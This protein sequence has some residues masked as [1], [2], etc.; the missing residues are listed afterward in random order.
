MSVIYVT[1]RVRN[2]MVQLSFMDVIFNRKV[3]PKGTPMRTRTDLY[4]MDEKSD[5]HPSLSDD[6]IRGAEYCYQSWI[7]KLEEFNSKYESFINTEDKSAFFHTFWI[8]KGTKVPESQRKVKHYDPHDSR[9]RR[10]DAPNDD[11]KDAL[12]D[13][14]DIFENDF[15]V[16]YHT[17]AYAYV[18][19]RSVKDAVKR[20]QQND[21]R[22]FLKL[23]FSNFF[24]SVTPEF[25]ENMFSILYP[26]G[27]IFKY[28][29]DF[30]IE[31]KKALS[32]CFLNGGLPQGTPMSPLLTN[33]IMIPIDSEIARG[34]WRKNKDFV[35]TRYADDI[36]IS[37]KYSF[38][39]TTIQEYI[40]RILGVMKAPMQL[41]TEKTRYGSRNGRNWN[42]GLMLNKDGDITIGHYK[43]KVFKT[44]IY[45][46]LLDYQN[47][48]YWSLHDVQV[49]NGQMQWY[50]S[51]EKESI[52]E[53][54]SHYDAKFG[55]N[56]AAIIK[57][58]L[59]GE[60]R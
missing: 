10:I 51:I 34:L 1:S 35:Y 38:H 32:I 54:I 27:Y 6:L 53:I 24:G 46:F 19:K 50:L 33:V 17:S 12:Y 55:L 13:L 59:K 43:K 56:T 58:Y 4:M 42:L 7:G 47:G 21:S 26:Y 40:T 2:P 9:F 22:W 45:N 29:E 31:F 30:K 41:N 48:N 23:D 37:S 60:V 20:H 28:H 44:S 36:L 8:P 14:K 25:V 3:E 39:W 49:F 57:S 16:L 52:S 18:K 11:L 5:K 15:N